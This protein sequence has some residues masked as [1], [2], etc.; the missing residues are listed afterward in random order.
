MGC[1]GGFS[2]ARGTRS[3]QGQGEEREDVGQVLLGEGD[4]VDADPRH[5]TVGGTVM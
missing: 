2:Q 5:L 4:A 1:G 3:A